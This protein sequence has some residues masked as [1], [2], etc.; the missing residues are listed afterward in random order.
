MSNDLMH[1]SVEQIEQAA[2]LV[3]VGSAVNVFGLSV[4]CILFSH[5][6][7]YLHLKA[8]YNACI[9]N[10]YPVSFKTGMIIP[11]PKVKVTSD[12]SCE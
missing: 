5:P 6:V 12:M 1:L 10:G 9:Q 8:V 4:E 11:V 7:I 2:S 3:N